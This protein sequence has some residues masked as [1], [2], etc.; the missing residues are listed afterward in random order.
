MNA[1]LDLSPEE[2]SF[3]VLD[4]IAEF[5]ICLDATKHRAC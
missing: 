2:W 4:A 1:D 5:Q 3:P